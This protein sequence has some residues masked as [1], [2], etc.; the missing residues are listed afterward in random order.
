MISRAQAL[1]ALKAMEIRGRRPRIFSQ[2]PPPSTDEDSFN[3]LSEASR[4]RSSETTASAERG[5]QSTNFDVLFD[6]AVVE[7]SKDGVNE[8]SRSAVTGTHEH[9]RGMADI[10]VLMRTL[11][12]GVSA[13]PAEG[14]MALAPL[15]WVWLS[16][17]EAEERAR[18]L[19]REASFAQVP[20]EYYKLY[21]A[22]FLFW[23][24]CVVRS[25]RKFPMILLFGYLLVGGGA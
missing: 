19:Y 14:V 9:H 11:K 22:Y 3:Q 25:R 8:A 13:A 1:S 15:E 17:V 5:G 7:T 20:P 23:F 16:R 6:A 24:M 4:G 10:A 2:A 12:D 21:P 18:E